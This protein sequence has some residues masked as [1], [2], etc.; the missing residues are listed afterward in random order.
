MYTA[1]ASLRW[2]FNERV[3]YKIFTYLLSLVT[4]SFI[5]SVTLVHSVCAIYMCGPVFYLGLGTWNVELFLYSRST[6]QFYMGVHC[7]LYT[8][9]LYTPLH[10]LC[11]EFTSVRY[12]RF[13]L[14]FMHCLYWTMH[15]QSNIIF[16]WV[17][18]HFCRTQIVQS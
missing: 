12:T 2:R 7:T 3:V 11:V 8:V 17:V 13:L 6:F 14:I 10:H 15:S 16:R 9:H 5:H 1:F 4:P 18:R